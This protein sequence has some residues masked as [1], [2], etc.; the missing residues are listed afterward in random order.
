MHTSFKW[1][2]HEPFSLSPSNGS[3][4]PKTSCLI[5]ATFSPKVCIP[6]I[7]FTDAVDKKFD[8][9]IEFGWDIMHDKTST[10]YSGTSNFS[11]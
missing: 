5:K 8:A 7:H 2:I 1:S 4:A 9:V 10:M 3:L 11:Y 6:V